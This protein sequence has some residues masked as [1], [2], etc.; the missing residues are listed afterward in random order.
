VIEEEIV[1]QRVTNLY[2]QMYDVASQ[3]VVAVNPCKITK[4]KCRAGRHVKDGLCCRGCKYLGPNGCTTKNLL[5]RSWLECE[6]ETKHPRIY[7]R[8]K[9]SLR[10]L[11]FYDM[12]PGHA[13]TSE[14]RGSR[15][16]CIGESVRRVMRDFRFAEV[17][18]RSLG[19][20]LEVSR[21]NE[22]DLE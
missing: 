7:N 8:F 20:K 6:I 19:M 14:F 5:C 16:D 17:K 15:E 10:D 18:F 4:G 1:R 13:I 21:E 22:H 9:D 11:G 3:A 2:D 12:D